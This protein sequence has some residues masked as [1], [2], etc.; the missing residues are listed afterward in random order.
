MTAEMGKAVETETA[1]A[2]GVTVQPGPV[3]LFSIV[4]P[5]WNEEEVIADTL[6]DLTAHLDGTGHHY[7]I[8][9]VDDGSTDRTP[10]ILRDFAAGHPAIRPV[11]NPGPGGYGFAI[12]RGLE[13]YRGDAVVVVTSDGADAPKDVAAY[14]DRIAQGHDCVFGDR[15]APGATVTGYPPVKRFVNR[16]ANWM[17]SLMVGR[18]YRDFTNGFKCYRRHVIEDMQPLVCGQFNITIEMSLKAVLAGWNYAVIPND[19]SQRGG[20][21]SSFRL[22]RL[23][24]P[25]AATLFFCLS[26]AYLLGVRRPGA[27]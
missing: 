2:A 27:K 24:K 8:V 11:K 16:A 19:W 4:M 17:I 7:E 3:R 26:R 15:F 22:L 25:Y 10:D 1:P 9:V 12:R 6:R 18:P 21:S 13:H 14:F 23:V 5:A 20:G